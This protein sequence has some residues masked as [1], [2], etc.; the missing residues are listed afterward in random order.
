MKIE[1]CQHVDEFIKGDVRVY[2][3]N[4]YFTLR[5]ILSQECNI[6]MENSDCGSIGL[7]TEFY[8]SELSIKYRTYYRWKN[9]SNFGKR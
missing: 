1:K 9:E 4:D 3:N 5:L 6:V 2:Q 8:E 7:S